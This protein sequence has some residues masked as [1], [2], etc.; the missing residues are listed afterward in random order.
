VTSGLRLSRDRAA[1]LVV[2]VQDRLAP[3]MPDA[4]LAQ[5]VRN[6]SVLIDVALRLDLPVVVSQQYPKGL[7][8]TLEAIAKL[9][10]DRAHRFDKLDFS[11]AHHLPVLGRDQWI[12]T[13]METHICVYQTARGV[14]ERGWQA[15][16]AI[17]A[18]ASRTKLNWKIGRDLIARAGGIVTSTETVVFDLLGCAGTDEFKALS[19]LIK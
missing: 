15:H 14:V 5:L 17:D 10:P 9:L 6:T 13:G 1:L 12:V 18:C 4:V 11:A 19:R 2:D 7:G 8:H 16:A 3:A